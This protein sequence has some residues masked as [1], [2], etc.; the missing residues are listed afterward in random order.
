MG[1]SDPS[2]VL[3][4]RFRTL[5]SLHTLVV[6]DDTFLSHLNPVEEALVLVEAPGRAMY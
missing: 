4:C 1:P 5:L 2:S 3:K 6:A